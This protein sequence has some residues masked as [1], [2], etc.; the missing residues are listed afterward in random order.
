MNKTYGGITLHNDKWV[1][2]KL[3]PHV[4]IKLKNVF[5]KVPK[6]SSGPFKFDNSAEVCA[7]LEWFMSRYP[8]SISPDHLIELQRNKMLFL[9]TQAEMER[10][11]CPEFIPGVY[12]TKEGQTLRPYQAQAV[13][14]FWRTK[15]LLV[16]DD[17]GL[18]KSYV[19]I[20]SCLRAEQLPAVVVVPTHL[21]YQWQEKIEAFSN[22]KV[23]CIK[24]TRPYSLP[25]ADVYIT[26]YTC[27][28]GWVDIFAQGF[29]KTAIFDEIADLRAG[30]GTAKG[31]GA[32][33]LCNNTEWK[34][35]L[36]GT[37][38]YNYADEIWNIMSI[39]KSHCLGTRDEFLRE[40][41]SDRSTTAKVI[42]QNPQALGSYYV[43]TIN[44]QRSFPQKG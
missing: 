31:Q 30:T 24:G 14:I 19:G 27:L 26:K 9:E 28:S 33:E 41:A 12:S 2:S 6:T 4:S 20:A 40:W 15:A 39:L 43:S 11:M 36:S 17:L 8:L 7:D 32:K 1:L 29:F 18:G 25:P 37:P 38:I 16:G 13:E 3:E 34:L 10:I 22:L 21:V 35:G 44:R 23:H 42:I 5:P